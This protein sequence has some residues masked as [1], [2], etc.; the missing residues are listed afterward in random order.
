MSLIERAFTA[1]VFAS[2]AWVTLG[3]MMLAGFVV[4]REHWILDAA[5]TVIAV[6]M[7]GVGLVILIAI[8]WALWSGTRL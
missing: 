2:I 6:G 5:L 1:L 8:A 7:I 4:I 3:G